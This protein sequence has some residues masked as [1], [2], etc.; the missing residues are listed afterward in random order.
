MPGRFSVPPRRPRSWG[1]PRNSGSN[2]VPA[3]TISAPAPLGPP[4]LWPEIT[5]KSAPR[6]SRRIGILPA[7]WTAS[8]TTRIPRAAAAAAIAASGWITPVSLLASITATTVVSAGSA[9][10]AAGSTSPSRPTPRCP[11][12]KPVRASTSAAPWTA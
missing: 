10:T 4:S 11:M 3:R 12:A 8:H 2:G 9:A 7:A 6:S 1:L 5:R